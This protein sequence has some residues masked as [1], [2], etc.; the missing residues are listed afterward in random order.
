MHTERQ[1]K[2]QNQYKSNRVPETSRPSVTYPDVQASAAM[3]VPILHSKNYSQKMGGLRIHES[4]TR[5]PALVKNDVSAVFTD[6]GHGDLRKMYEDWRA[7]LDYYKVPRL[8]RLDSKLPAIPMENSLSKRRL[9]QHSA[10]SPPSF[11]NNK[12]SEI[13]TYNHRNVK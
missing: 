7:G 3:P 5:L 8:C 4:D 13:A 2:P 10:S 1:G 11:R 6:Q 12:G 9:S